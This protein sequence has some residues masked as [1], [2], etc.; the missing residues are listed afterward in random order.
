MHTR[1]IQPSD[2]PR[3][4]ELW[5]EKGFDC[6]KPDFARIGGTVLVDNDGT[7]RMAIAD[8][9]TT[10]LYMFLDRGK[11]ATPG[12]KWTQFERLH[13]AERVSLQ[14]R[15]Y[16]DAHVWVPRCARSF[17]HKLRKFFGWVDSNGPDG[18]WAGLT[19]DV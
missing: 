2:I 14:E 9:R 13:E 15:G 10:E 8:R 12:M 3:L 4:E 19:R 17:A 7:V 5:E 11:W 6:V 16:E 18:T 1:P